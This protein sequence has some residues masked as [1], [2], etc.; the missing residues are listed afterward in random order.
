V[1][2]VGKIE[3]AIDPDAVIENGLVV[4]RVDWPLASLWNPVLPAR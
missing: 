3:A 1:A 4:L 2:V